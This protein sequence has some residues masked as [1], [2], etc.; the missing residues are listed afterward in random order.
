MKLLHFASMLLALAAFG[1][2]QAQ[3]AVVKTNFLYDA[4]LTPSL[5]VE[6]GVAPRWTLDVSGQYNGWTV[7]SHRWRHWLVQPE[8]RYWL[9]DTFEGHFFGFHFFGGQ[10]NVGNISNSF[11]FLG[12]DFSDLS[13]N[14]HQGWMAGAGVAY[15]Y[16]WILSR[17]WNLEAEIGI[18]WA[19]TRYDIYPCVECGTKLGSRVH[20]YVGPTKLAL[21]LEYVF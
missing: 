13:H 10:Y 19:Y 11:K 16:S 8:A 2:C 18:G 7:N 6:F 1:H 17:H 4:A 12:T 5:G 14:R 15:G 21:N 20:N 9:C 3:K